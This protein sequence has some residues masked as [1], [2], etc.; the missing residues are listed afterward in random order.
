MK[1][2]VRSIC[3]FCKYVYAYFYADRIISVYPNIKAKDHRVNIF[4]YHP[5]ITEG[6]ET[7]YMNS[8][9]NLGDSLGIVVTSYML[10]KKDCLSSLG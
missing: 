3:L 8:R 9:W 10:E 1:R 2:F 7:M 5:E 6:R 4:D